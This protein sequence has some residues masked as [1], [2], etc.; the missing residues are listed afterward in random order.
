MKAKQRAL[1]KKLFKLVNKR[2]IA[3]KA[4]IEEIVKSHKIPS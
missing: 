1:I 2:L 3:E 4:L